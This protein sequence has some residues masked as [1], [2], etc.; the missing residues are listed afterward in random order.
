[1]QVGDRRH[2][3]RSYVALVAGLA[4][5]LLVLMASGCTD[6]ARE[7]PTPGEDRVIA[8]TLTVVAPPGVVDRSLTRAFRRAY[9]KVTLRLVTCDGDEIATRLEGDLAADVVAVTSQETLPLL[10]S[11]RLVQAIDVRRLTE[12][13]SIVP[14]ARRFPTFLS[15]GS[16]CAVPT[17]VDLVGIAL[18]TG[19]GS[20]VDSLADL[21]SPRLKGKAAMPDRPVLGIEMGALA[22]GYEVPSSLSD[23]QLLNVKAL[24][25]DNEDNF[26]RFWSRP[27]E[28]ARLFRSGA[29][30]ASPCDLAQVTRLR[31]VGLPVS[32]VRPSEGMLASLRGFAIAAHAPNAPAGYAFLDCALSHP[33]QKLVARGGRTLAVRSDVQLSAPPALLGTV[34]IESLLATARPVLRPE[35]YDT[36]IVAWAQAKKKGRG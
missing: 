21:F 36:W 9:P 31:R 4:A 18:A 26:R 5:V 32:F 17:G 29:L 27:T 28:L 7:T 33:V 15:D 24:Y 12:W 23:D 22:L 10:V 16:T 11:R 8:G 30:L 25:G 35:R 6:T 2:P 13:K 34:D 14:S 1:V 20:D 3:S 19:Q